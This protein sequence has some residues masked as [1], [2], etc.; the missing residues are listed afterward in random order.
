ML[1]ATIWKPNYG[2]LIFDLAESALLVSDSTPRIYS[3]ASKTKSCLVCYMYTATCC[4]G[5]ILGSHSS[6]QKHC[7]TGGVPVYTKTG[8]EA[9]HAGYSRLICSVSWA[10]KEI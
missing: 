2:T 4:S 7:K 3:E 1:T 5:G 6:L 8:N 9:T 10:R